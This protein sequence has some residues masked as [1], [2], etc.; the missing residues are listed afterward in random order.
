M[1]KRT[2][3]DGL[4]VLSAGE[5]G[6][7]TV[8]PESWRLRMVARVKGESSQATT[9]GHRLHAEWAKKYDE[10]VA[11]VKLIRLFVLLF[12]LAALLYWWL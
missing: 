4:H 11:L 3:A 2:V 9:E 8:C 12:I 6:A 1:K 7:Y 10:S 5:I